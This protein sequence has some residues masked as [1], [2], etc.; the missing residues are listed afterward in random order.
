MEA[1]MRQSTEKLQQGNE[2]VWVKVVVVFVFESTHDVCSSSCG[3]T[4]WQLIHL[5]FG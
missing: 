3:N 2:Q 4:V 5:V 1:Y